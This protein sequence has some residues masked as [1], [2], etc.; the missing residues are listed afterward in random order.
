MKPL[1]QITL[2]CMCLLLTGCYVNRKFYYESPLTANTSYYYTR[3][4]LYD[5]VTSAYYA[6]V[7]IYSGFAND[8]KS[9]MVNY[10][11]Y[12]LYKAGNI[13]SFQYYY[14]LN[15][16]FGDYQHSSFDSSY[17]VNNVNPFN[18]DDRKNKF[19]AFGLHGGISYTV[20]T[21]RTEW[22]AIGLDYSFTREYG[23]YLKFRNS[24]KDDITDG[25]IKDN[26]LH[27]LGINTEVIA[28]RTKSDFG[29]KTGFGYILND[30]YLHPVYT[31]PD[32]PK[33][34]YYYFLMNVHY[35][36]KRSTI[37]FQGTTGKF[38]NGITFGATYR[39]SK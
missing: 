29:F 31:N 6:N 23:N 16:L 7:S 27:T 37:Y 25:N 39:L 30:A 33:E 36:R 12:L 15:F 10:S 20:S 2:A 1:T 32:A 4:K 21:P 38:S 22:R 26:Y 34:A 35:T 13:K 3:P 17:F 24:L 5:S 28:K 8:Y 9:D 19:Y 11:S 14:G 18:G